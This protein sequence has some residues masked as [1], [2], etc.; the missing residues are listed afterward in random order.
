MPYGSLQTIGQVHLIKV[1]GVYRERSLDCERR[2][3]LGVGVV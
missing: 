3:I 1:L 2:L